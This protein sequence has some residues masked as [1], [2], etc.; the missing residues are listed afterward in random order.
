MLKGFPDDL[1]KNL[2]AM[3]ESWIRP[4]GQKN[5]PKKGMTIHSSILA[6][7]IP[8]TEEPGRLH[9]M[10]LQRV[11]CYVESLLFFLID[12]YTFICIYHKA[13]IYSSV[14]RYLSYFQ[15]LATMNKV[16]L[17]IYVSL[18]VDKSLDF[19]QINA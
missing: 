13:F 6:L 15:F 10:G 16:A 7:R 19:F 18:S 9:S 14:S 11:G 3:Q 5:P 2:P 4:L 1:V 8:W 17:N 12:Q